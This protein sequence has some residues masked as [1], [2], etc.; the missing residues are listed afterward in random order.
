MSV[1]AMV[2][3]TRRENKQFDRTKGVV[4]AKEYMYISEAFFRNNSFLLVN[5]LKR[6]AFDFLFNPVD[7]LK[8]DHLSGFGFY[9][10]IF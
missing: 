9:D 10:P 5:A 6:L 3:S 2:K 8:P 4:V 7:Q 1:A